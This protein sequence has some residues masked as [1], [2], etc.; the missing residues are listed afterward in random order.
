[1]RAFSDMHDEGITAFGHR[2]SERMRPWTKE[3]QT[4]EDEGATYEQWLLDDE[5]G[6]PGLYRVR[7]KPAEIHRYVRG[8][9]GWDQFLAGDWEAVSDRD[10]AREARQSADERSSADETVEPGSVCP[11]DFLG[12]Q[13]EALVC[14]W[15]PERAERVR[16]DWSERNVVA[17]L[18]E[19]A[20]SL[21]IAI[22][23]V[24]ERSFIEIENE[25]DL[26][27]ALF[28]ILRSLFTDARREEWVPS[29]AGGAK[30]VDLA[31]PGAS[32]L[33]EVKFVRDRSHG[34]RVADELRIDIESYHGHPSCGTLFALIWDPNHFLLDPHQ[35]ERDLS[36]VRTK[37]GTSFDVAVRVA[38]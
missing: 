22:R 17:L 27:D 19:M 5:N 6:G 29:S 10:L 28:L 38:A 35:L 8:L 1:M 14:G 9:V 16:P 26:H 15:Q 36:G 13:I 20:S 37:A 21:P 30:R 11:A 2:F 31:I 34:K 32:V 24:S 7:F 25:K 4:L 18:H 23:A 12:P 3:L 33:I